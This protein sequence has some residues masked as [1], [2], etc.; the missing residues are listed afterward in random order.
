MKREYRTPQTDIVL[1]SIGEIL[2]EDEGTKDSTGDWDEWNTN[3]SLFEEDETADIQNSK[4]LW[5]E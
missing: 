2:Q 1:L 5:E 4:S 3:Q